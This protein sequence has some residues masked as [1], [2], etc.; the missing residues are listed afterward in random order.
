MNKSLSI[1]IVVLFTLLFLKSEFLADSEPLSDPRSF[2]PVLEL[3]AAFDRARDRFSLYEIWLAKDL[4]LKK[5][6]F[7][8]YLYPALLGLFLFWIDDTKLGLYPYYCGCYDTTKLNKISLLI[9]DILYEKYIKHN[10]LSLSTVNEKSPHL[11]VR[12]VTCRYDPVRS[13]F[14]NG[15][16]QANRIGRQIVLTH[17]SWLTLTLLMINL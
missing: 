2:R 6:R 3:L 4:E 12:S 15:T 7:W 17:E 8:F 14:R 16:S 11:S 1:G 10:K 5:V 9:K 13:N